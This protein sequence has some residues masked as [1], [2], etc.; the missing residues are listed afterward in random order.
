MS[1]HRYF[2]GLVL[3]ALVLWAMAAVVMERVP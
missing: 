3:V 1:A 2:L